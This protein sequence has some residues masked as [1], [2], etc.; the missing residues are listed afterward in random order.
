MFGRRTT[1]IEEQ[2]TRSAASLLYG[3][4]MAWDVPGRGRSQRASGRRAAVGRRAIVAGRRLAR[5][6]PVVAVD[7]R[8][9]S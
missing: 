7:A 6:Q 9:C 4:A 1:G 3:H 8:P 2:V 5:R